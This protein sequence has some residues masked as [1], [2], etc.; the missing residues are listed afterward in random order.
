MISEEEKHKQQLERREQTNRE[1]EAKLKNIFLETEEQDRN[2]K[3]EMDLENI[4]H[5][6]LKLT[7]CKQCKVEDILVFTN[8]LTRLYKVV[9]NVQIFNGMHNRNNSIN[10]QVISHLNYRRKKEE[11]KITTQDNHYNIVSHKI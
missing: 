9:N 10:F 7:V 5:Q 6:T 4:K 1:E 3:R 11:D 2:W 8:C